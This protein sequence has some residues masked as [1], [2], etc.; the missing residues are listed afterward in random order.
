MHFLPHDN[1]MQEVN[2]LHMPKLIPQVPLILQCPLPYQKN[3]LFQKS[4][5]ILVGAQFLIT[6]LFGPTKF[7]LIIVLDMWW[8]Q[9]PSLA[10]HL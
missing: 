3:S 7:Q 8:Y 9:H 5:V 6:L 10:S 2:L 1:K 4:S